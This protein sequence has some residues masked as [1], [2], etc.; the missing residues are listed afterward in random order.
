MLSFSVKHDVE[1][2]QRGEIALKRNADIYALAVASQTLQQ[3]LAKQTEATLGARLGR[4]WKQRLYKNA[5]NPAAMVYTLAPSIITTFLADTVTV[6]QHGKHLAV[7]TGFNRAGGRRGGKVRVT[8]KQMIESKQSFVRPRKAGPGLIWFLKIN[9]ANART[10][11]VG[12][13]GKVLLGPVKDMAIAGGLAQVGRFGRS[14]RDILKARAVPMFVLLPQTA[15]KRRLDAEAETRRIETELP[16]YIA[17]GYQVYD[18]S[19]A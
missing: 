9:L 7:P 15:H 10:S 4:A 6:P 11:R 8:P 19:A 5:Q 16:G 1:G 13:N 12:K 2:W 14:T 18:R 3:R 17:E